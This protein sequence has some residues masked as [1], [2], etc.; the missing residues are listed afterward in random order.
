VDWDRT[1]AEDGRNPKFDVDMFTAG[2]G[3]RF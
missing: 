1:S 3:Y 2:V